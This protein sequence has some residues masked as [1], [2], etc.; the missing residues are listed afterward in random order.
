M[1]VKFLW[2]AIVLFTMINQTGFAQNSVKGRVTDKTNNEALP[3][4]SVYI[5]EQNKGTIAEKNGEFVLANLPKGEL[6]IQF[7]YVGYKTIIRT[8]FTENTE[9]IL[10]VVMEPAILQAE[11]VVISGGTY[12]TQHDNAIKIDLIKSRDIASM[13]TPT[14]IEALA[15]V[16]GVDMIAKGTGVAKPVI[17]GL[18]M[19][20]ILMLNNGVKMESFQFSE[21]HPFIIDEFG[22]DHIEIIKG[23]ASL[24]YGSDAV[25]GVINVLKEKPAPTGKILG[26]YNMQYHSNTQG[27]V[28]NLGVKGSS[29]NYFWGLRGGVKNHTDYRDGNGDY[30]PNTRFNEYSFKVNAGI[31]KPFGLF[32]LYYDYN[33][34]K[35]GM[36]VGDA[37]LLTT[38]NG[39]KNKLW[40]QD[41]I[42]HIIS[43]RNALFFG[44]Y[45][46]DFNAA[47]QMNNRRLQTDENKPSFEMVD[48]DLNTFSYEVKTYLPSTANSEYIVGLQG[49]NK[50]NRN[51]EAPNHVLPDADV[52]DFSV[53]GL[54]QYTFFEKLI[55]QAGIRY[56]FR[57]I[58]TEA[59]TNKEAVNTNYGNVSASLGAT[60]TVNKNILIRTNFAS[61]HRTPNIAELTQNGMHGARYEQGTPELKTQRNYEADI[62][63][64]FHSE[65]VMVDIAGFYHSINDYI[66]IAPTDDTIASGD[67]IYRYS[68]TNSIIYGSELAID[69]LPFNWLNIKT[70]YAYLIGK[71][72]DGSNLPFIPQNKLRFELKFQKQELAFLKNTFFKI[73]GLIAAKQNNPAMF[74]TETDSYYLLNT[75]IGTDIKWANQ[76]VYLSVQAN[77]LLNE[78]YIDHLSTLKGMG[79][80]NIGRN[81]S[82]NL[83][84]PLRIYEKH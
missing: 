52:N 16:P 20:N 36:C 27:V 35:L 74:E 1:K 25:G 55:A 68:Q 39:R 62:S 58:S 19:T 14:F 48:M 5:P 72:D 9:V 49:A 78:T 66:F 42:N 60:Y 22:I 71:Q 64:H 80:Y 4:T 7:S 56:D 32:R 2:F 65:Y 40:Y 17:R 70:S 84:I 44:K 67:K 37:V 41:L 50:T 59:E 10:N 77:N 82:V 75:G 23:P 81:I 33:Q 21:N 61:A 51:S 15:N 26:D 53:F 6:K 46:I 45:K 76:M 54:A 18:S 38:E 34:P 57:S 3:F 30:V 43:T 73:G 28:S 83:K 63:T 69:V 47:Y 8:I 31:N 12:S 29:E 24:L 13:G 79:Y 11:E